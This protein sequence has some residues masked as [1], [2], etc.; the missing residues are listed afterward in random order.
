VQFPRG[1]E[2]EQE[3]R[4]WL[5]EYEM[6]S[7]NFSVCKLLEQLGGGTLTE[8]VRLHDSITGATQSQRLA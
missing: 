5:S 8:V 2:E 3:F 1:Q 6:A 4:E 7:R